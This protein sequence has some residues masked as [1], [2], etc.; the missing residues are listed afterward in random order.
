MLEQEA[1]EKQPSVVSKNKFPYL[2]SSKIIPY[3]WY[4]EEH[5]GILMLA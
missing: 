3:W 2:S 1:P 4:F 5:I